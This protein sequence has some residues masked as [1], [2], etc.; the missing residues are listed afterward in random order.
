MP[1]DG[2]KPS[3]NFGYTLTLL[4]LLLLAALA[5]LLLFPSY[6]EYRKKKQLEADRI[7]ER[8]NLQAM[9]AESMRE[10]HELRNSREATEKVSREKFN[11]VRPGETVL[12]FNPE[13]KRK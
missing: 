4:A 2:K 11:Q 13:G 3:F 6:R 5:V 9:R 1:R 8:D 12:V 10:N 7:R